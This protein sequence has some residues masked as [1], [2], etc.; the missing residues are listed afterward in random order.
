[1][2]FGLSYDDFSDAPDANMN[3]V[4]PSQELE[5]CGGAQVF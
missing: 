4:G 2:Y 1:M 3:G 5:A